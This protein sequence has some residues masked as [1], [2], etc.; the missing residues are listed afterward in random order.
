MSI[1]KLIAGVRRFRE[2]DFP[3]QEALYRELARGQHPST[4]FITCSDSRIEPQRLTRSEPGELFVLRNAGAAVPPQE[5]G[6]S[7]AGTIQFAIDVLGVRDVIVCGHTRCGA[8]MAALEEGG[9]LAEK[10]PAVHEWL[11]RSRMLENLAAARIEAAGTDQDFFEAVCQHVQ[12]QIDNLKTYPF[13]RS[14]V[15]SGKI[16]LHAWVLR[17]ARGEVWG[18][19]SAARFVRL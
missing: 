2:E 10:M 13:V 15:A 3:R 12:H 11:S 1:D 19:D 14:A 5:V 16:S 18:Q 9:Q 7:E 17:L 6:S 4:L 8:V